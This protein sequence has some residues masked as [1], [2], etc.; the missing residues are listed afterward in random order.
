MDLCL[1]TCIYIN[2][3]AVS[4]MRISIKHLEGLYTLAKWETFF[5]SNFSVAYSYHH[6]G[7][8]TCICIGYTM[9]MKGYRIY[10]TEGEA[11][12]RVDSITPDPNC[13]TGLFQ[14]AE[15]FPFPIGSSRAVQCN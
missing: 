1:S 15:A 8:M 10:T 5:F 11:R 6:Q 13:I 9:R 3:G 14:N 2:C 7:I 12:G 4:G